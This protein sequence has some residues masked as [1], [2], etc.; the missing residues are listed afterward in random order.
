MANNVQVEISGMKFNVKSDVE[1][2][3][4]HAIAKYVEDKLAEVS[5]DTANQQSTSK[6]AIL[7]CL[8]IACELFRLRADHENLSSTCNSRADEMITAI[9]TVLK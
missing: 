8:N 4:L 5:T 3:E 9:E 1:P 6:I 7:T 2:L